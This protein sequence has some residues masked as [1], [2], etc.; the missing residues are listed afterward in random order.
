MSMTIKEIQKE[1]ILIKQTFPAR[2]S[3]LEGLLDR[4]KKLAK[5]DGKEADPS[6]IITAAKQLIK[7]AQKNIEIL[8]T[9]TVDQSSFIQ[10]D[11]NEIAIYREFLPEQVSEEKLRE[12]IHEYIDS[13]VPQENMKSM[14]KVMKMVQ[15]TFGDTADRS[16]ASKI[17]K[18]RLA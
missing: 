15:Y 4:A 1:R 17:I 5:A 7:T 12:A 8:K 10:R 6:Y 18:E 16:L 3:A 2:S 14:G 11:E 13:S 9:A